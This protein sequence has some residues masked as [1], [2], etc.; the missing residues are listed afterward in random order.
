MRYLYTEYL[1]QPVILNKYIYELNV[2]NNATK[3]GYSKDNIDLN[4]NTEMLQSIDFRQNKNN[5]QRF[6]E[7]LPDK[8]QN[9]FDPKYKIHKIHCGTCD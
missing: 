2:T 7:K 6:G 3:Q 9:T 1:I 5:L 8:G 4:K